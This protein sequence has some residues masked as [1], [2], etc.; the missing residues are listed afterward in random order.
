VRSS[1]KSGSCWGPLGIVGSET[2]VLRGLAPELGQGTPLRP[3][4]YRGRGRAHGSQAGC[5]L[6]KVSSGP[7]G[8]RRRPEDPPP[9]PRLARRHWP[10]QPNRPPKSQKRHADLLAGPL[11]GRVLPLREL[12]A[13]DDRTYRCGVAKGTCTNSASSPSTFVISVTRNS[14]S[15]C[16]SSVFVKKRSWSWRTTKLATSAAMRS[17]LN[18]SSMSVDALVPRKPRAV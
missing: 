2:A 8:A 11:G 13:E 5:L 10:G 15:D 16:Q 12:L 17:S 1:A 6:V 7:I 4:G 14:C 18:W 3:C 9:P